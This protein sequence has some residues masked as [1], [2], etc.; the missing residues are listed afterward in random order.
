MHAVLPAET[1]ARQGD[2]ALGER[3]GGGM[4]L[5]PFQQATILHRPWH[6]GRGKEC[7]AHDR[8]QPEAHRL[9]TPPR[10]SLTMC[11]ISSERS[12]SKMMNSSMRLTNSGLKCLRTC[13]SKAS[14]QARA[15]GSA[16]IPHPLTLNVTHPASIAAVRAYPAND[17]SPLTQTHTHLVHDQLLHRLLAGLGRR[18]CLARALELPH[19]L[20][21][22]PVD[23]VGTE[24]GG[25]DDD[26][27]LCNR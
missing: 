19:A 17:A 9:T 7:A 24:I 13:S 8:S 6:R 2:V 25:H 15:Q 14:Q 21:S 22:F 26:D 4:R 3:G 18:R 10:R 1:D 20:G 27:V 16:P 23:L 5:G 12:G 11:R